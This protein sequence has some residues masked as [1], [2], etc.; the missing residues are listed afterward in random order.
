MSASLVGRTGFWR[1]RR[2]CSG[3][4]RRIRKRRARHPKELHAKI[5]ELTLG[6]DLLS[7]ALGNAGLRCAKRCSTAAISSGS[8]A[9]RRRSAMFMLCSEIRTGLAEP[10]SVNKGNPVP[11]GGENYDRGPAWKL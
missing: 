1:A 9:K 5:N 2:A 11:E 3:R 7:G 4:R 10:S 8:P 6:N